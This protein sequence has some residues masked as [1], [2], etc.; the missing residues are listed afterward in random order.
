MPENNIIKTP[1][2]GTVAAVD[3]VEQFGHSI[4]KL[5]E[6]LGVTR[7][8]GLSQGNKLQTYKYVVTKPTDEDAAKGIIAEGEDVPLTHVK[9]ELDKEIEVS[10]RK[11][12][13]AVTME[14]VQ[15]VGYE[16]AVAESDA[17]VQREIQKDTRRDFFNFL[18]TAPTTI[19]SVAGLQESFGKLW[20]KV[21][22]IFDD[23]VGVIVFI[24]P[25]DAGNYL[26]DAVITNGQSVGFGLTLL[27]GFTNVRVLVNNSVPQGSVYATAEN[28]LNIAYLNTNGEAAKVF[29]G[30]PV[31]TDETGLIGLVKDDNTTNFTNQS[32]IFTGL[33]IFAEV[34]NGVVKA[35][36]APAV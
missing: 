12:R 26:G 31:I 10:F 32:S 8:T 2:M 5:Q 36:I 20:G 3:F 11:Y 14:E 30:K 28:N 35:T 33:T 23:E 29:E 7:L 15:R 18:G 4:T 17:Q 9:R 25:I 34:T 27:T 16:V 19:G 1:D 13:K 24:N 21:T 22:D 6:A